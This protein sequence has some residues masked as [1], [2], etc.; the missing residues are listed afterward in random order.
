ML[1]VVQG[2]LI[3]L[4]VVFVAGTLLPIMRL[5]YWWIRLFDSSRT[6]E[7]VDA[8]RQ[9]RGHRVEESQEDQ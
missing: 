8:G 9:D 2:V 1:L 7:V 5:P 4:A 6:H 3:A